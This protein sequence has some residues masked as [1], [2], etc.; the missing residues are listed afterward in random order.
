MNFAPFH[1]FQR[2]LNGNP[3][4]LM[5]PGGQ[6]F[7]TMPHSK[8]QKFWSS[9]LSGMGKV[10]NVNLPS[11]GTGKSSTVGHCLDALITAVRNKIQEVGG[12]TFLI[13]ISKWRIFTDY[14]NCMFCL[15]YRS[16]QVWGHTPEQRVAA[17]TLRRYSFGLRL[18]IAQAD[19][20]P[21]I[22]ISFR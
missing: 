14:K 15:M 13:S 10:M 5:I 6:S 19:A 22:P 3:L 8:R 16:G 9:Q 1:W 18:A 20:R 7:Q 17:S 21:V 4:L 2:K 11:T 12:Y